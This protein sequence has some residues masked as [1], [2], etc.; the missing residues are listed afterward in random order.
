MSKTGTYNDTPF[1]IEHEGQTI[2]LTFT[3]TTP[4][5]AT[6]KWN[7]PAPAVGCGDD[8]GAYNGIV[9]TMD[10]KSVLNGQRPVNATYYTADPTAN[11]DLH[12]GDK[13]GDA[14]VVGAFYDDDVTTSLVVTD[15]E[16]NRPYYFS[17]YAVDKQGRYHRDGVHAYALEWAKENKDKDYPGYQE[18]RVLGPAT[19]KVNMETMKE[20]ATSTLHGQWTGLA[21][22][23]TYTLKAHSD[24]LPFTDIEIEGAT[25]QTYEELVK[26][27]NEK[28]ALAIAPNLNAGPPN[29][30]A[31]Y[32][33]VANK[34]LYTW[35]GVAYEPTAIWF[36]SD[37]PNNTNDGDFWFKPSTGELSERVSGAWE[38]RSFFTYHK[39]FNSLDGSDY[40]INGN[41]AMTWEGTTWCSRPL[42]TSLFD[43]SLAVTPVTGAFW[44]N[45]ED[46]MMYMWDDQ[47]QCWKAV[48]V[49]FH[50]TDPN[51][52]EEGAL[53]YNTSNHT[54]YVRTAGA[55]V[56]STASDAV[57]PPKAPADG[58]LWVDVKNDLVKRY[59]FATKTW[60]KADVI[61]WSAD[62]TNRK[63]CD[64]WWQSDGTVNKL[65]VWDFIN[66]VWVEATSFVESATDPR[67]PQLP[68]GQIWNRT[69]GHYFIWDGMEWVEIS[70]IEISHDPRQPVVDEILHVGT[71]WMK[72]NGTAWVTFAVDSNEIDPAN[73]PAGSYWY[74][75][76][77]KQLKLFNGLTWSAVPFSLKPQV[78]AVGTLYFDT[79]ENKLKTWKSGR[80][81]DAELPLRA[82]IN[83]LNNLMFIGQTK[84]SA[85]CVEVVFPQDY[86]DAA[87]P[88]F[89]I[90]SP[91]PGHDAVSDVPSYKQIGVGTD[92]SVDERREIIN[93][94][95]TDLGMGSVSV[96]LTKA[97]LERCVDS[98]LET[99]R[100]KSSAS[101]KRGFMFMDIQADVQ[102]YVLS[103][104]RSDYDKIVNVNG[105]FR[106]RGGRI[107]SNSYNDPFEQSMI[108][109]LYFAGSFDLLSYHLLSAYN[110]L[111]NEM[112]AN[113]L[114]FTWHEYSRTL[115][116]HQ[117]MRN[118]ERVLL[119]V[120]VERSEQDMFVDRYTRPWIIKWAT[121]K[122]MMIL[123][124]VRGKYG[125]LP[126]A[127]GGVTLNASDLR[128]QATEYFEQCLDD[129]D[130]FVVNS[131]EEVGLNSTI[132]L[133]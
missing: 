61:Y 59:D 31:Q 70:A 57:L 55:W 62:P 35:N 111:L 115:M 41:Q 127:G 63:S 132:M 124:E 60:V 65:W 45:T 99:L 112:F 86:R 44:Y 131:V 54:L 58:T 84:G 67:D 37:F 6:I 33:D 91:Y 89:F 103:S 125:S 40:W 19:K 79:I 17:A 114:M 11:T 102:K 78:P 88:W 75:T 36:D 64:K 108:Q 38:S 50:P 109:Q 73:I 25:A 46:G 87:K 13:I 133:G 14:F 122:A 107:G 92:G 100:Q 81:V 24:T 98:A 1:Q 48:N 123:A 26:Q 22:D 32:V 128:G 72:W 121:A 120:M 8:Q 49:I 5:T 113:N 53:W 83:E 27:F 71:A 52:M 85:G 39:P 56:K 118:K 66:S 29:V 77:A 106:V 96:E 23:K 101:V 7:I 68:V 10:D 116:L 43:P 9:I 12:A 2:D 20:P 74:D 126:G 80:W 94:V 130:N 76:V 69:D 30:G 34:R 21:T 117:M 104:K 129:V 15:I 3:K 110:E 82:T 16:S 28:I 105:V 51:A 18:V 4:D 97:A 90:D 47:G 119:D 95:L 42:I 93:A